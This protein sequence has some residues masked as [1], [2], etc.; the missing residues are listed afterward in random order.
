MLVEQT[1]DSAITSAFTVQEC[2]ASSLSKYTPIL[3][4][5]NLASLSKIMSTSAP[6]AQRKLRLFS[7]S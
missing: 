7:V 5:E 3:S 1:V 6:T 2:F 4:I